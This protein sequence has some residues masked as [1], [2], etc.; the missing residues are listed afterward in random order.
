[1]FKYSLRVI[2]YILV[3]LITAISLPT[4]SFGATLTL[5]GTGAALG[6]M[7][8][9][10]V[11]FNKHFPAASIDVRPSVGSSGGIRAVTEG[12]LDIGISSRALKDEELTSA[13]KVWAYAK[14]PFVLAVHHKLS[15]ANLTTQ[16]AIGIYDGSLLQWTDGTTVRV[17]LRSPTE[18]D[19]V[20]LKQFIP[21]MEAALATAYQR[22]GPPIATTDQDIADKIQS[23]PGAVGTSTLSLI[24][25]ENRPLKA[26]ALNNVAPTVENMGNGTYPMSK[27]LYLVTRAQA[28]A[29]VQQFIDFMQSEEGAAILKRTGHLML[30]SSKAK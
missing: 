28:K 15:V 18:T 4:S 10:A 27:T 20:I 3:I 12:M 23:I 11:A 29:E 13:I 26:L 22:R 9:L 30:D 21:G 24:L 25:G 2:R 7:K 5:G 16:Q 14:S 17:I 6:S 19:T 8:Q 1:M